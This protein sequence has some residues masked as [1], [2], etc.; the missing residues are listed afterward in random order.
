MSRDL[1]LTAEV[2]EYQTAAAL[3]GAR[4]SAHDVGKVRVVVGEDVVCA[5]VG[6][7]LST[8]QSPLSISQCCE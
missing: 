3:G 5:T 1:L 2:K 6:E 7:V 8:G 4:A